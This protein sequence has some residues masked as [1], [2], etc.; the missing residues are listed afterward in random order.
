[1]L[2]VLAVATLGGLGSIA[3]IVSMRAM[4]RAAEVSCANNLN[5]LWRAHNIQISQFHSA[6][7]MTDET[8]EAFWLYLT[9]KLVVGPSMPELFKCPYAGS[10]PGPCDYR[11]PR[12]S[13]NKFIADDPVGADKPGNHGVGNGGNVLQKQGHVQHCEEGSALWKACEIKL[14]P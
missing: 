13:V 9:Q 11:G 7:P 2:I 5:Q 14:A 8:G 1:M 10:L 3:L 6:G 12:Q 4:R